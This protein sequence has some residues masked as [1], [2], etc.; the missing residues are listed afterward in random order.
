MS[1]ARPVTDTELAHTLPR[2]AHDRGSAPCADACVRAMLTMWV[3]TAVAIGLSLALHSRENYQA[4]ARF[5]LL[6]HELAQ[7]VAS[8][9]ADPCY[10]QYRALHP[11]AEERTLANLIAHTCNGGPYP[12]GS[13]RTPALE[14]DRLPFV[15]R[16]EVQAMRGGKALPPERQPKNLRAAVPIAPAHEIAAA[17]AGF[18]APDLIHRARSASV[19]A[20]WLVYRWEREVYERVTTFVTQRDAGTPLKGNEMLVVRMPMPRR[21]SV[22]ATPESEALLE[23]TLTPEEAALLPDGL[24]IGTLREL[25]RFE[26]ATLEDAQALLQSTDV[27]DVPL[28]NARVPI[29]VAAVAVL[30]I[31]L[32][33][34]IWLF[35]HIHHW[36]RLRP[37]GVSDGTSLSAALSTTHARVLLACILLPPP[38]VAGALSS[39][40]TVP[41]VRATCVVLVS[42]TAFYWF[43]SMRLALAANRL[44]E[45][46][47]PAI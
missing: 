41:V 44:G 35:V 3:L 45:H 42:A 29:S 7:A 46:P 40:I 25:S 28:V 24:M 20:D 26:S 8:L 22:T 18:Y 21:P 10:R 37:D 33:T 17:L 30:A 11:E 6:R 4:L 2:T 34:T 9:D 39:S 47:N 23:R 31:M 15:F 13:I 38:F 43:T 14:G 1:T 32:L 12:S 16:L 36:L 5:V 27:I 19:A